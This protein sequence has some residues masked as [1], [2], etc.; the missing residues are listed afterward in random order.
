M[1]TFYFLIYYK[2]YRIRI[3]LFLC[4]QYNYFIRCIILAMIQRNKEWHTFQSFIKIFIGYE[5]KL[6]I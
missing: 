4:F 3:Y 1:I 6:I 5:I 2:L